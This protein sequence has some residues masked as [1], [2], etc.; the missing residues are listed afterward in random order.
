MACLKLT[1]SGRRIVNA[2][3]NTQLEVYEGN[4]CS[5]SLSI[6]LEKNAVRIADNFNNIFQLVSSDGYGDTKKLFCFYLKCTAACKN[7]FKLIEKKYHF[8]FLKQLR[9]LLPGFTRNEIV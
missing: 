8:K 7:P 3:H 4:R 6:F 9:W 5:L 2:L 1:T